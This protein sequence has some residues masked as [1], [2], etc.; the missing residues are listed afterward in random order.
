MY[1]RVRKITGVSNKF[2]EGRDELKESIIEVF[3]RNNGREESF[4][5]NRC[6]K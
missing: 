5:N 6:A 1:A 4:N 2:G 3:G